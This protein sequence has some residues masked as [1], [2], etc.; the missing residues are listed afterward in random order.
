MCILLLSGV[1]YKGQQ[2]KLANSDGQVYYILAAFS[3]SRLK[4]MLKS[5]PFL[6]LEQK[7]HTYENCTDLSSN[8]GSTTHCLH[9]LTYL[10]FSLLICKIGIII[11]PIM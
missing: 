2:V 1:F 4:S 5:Y 8:Y 11:A 9:A 7:D 6:K 10:G 3:K